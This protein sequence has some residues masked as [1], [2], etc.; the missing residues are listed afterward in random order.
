MFLNRHNLL[1]NHQTGTNFILA[2]LIYL[3][4]EELSESFKCN[5]H[6]YASN[7]FGVLFALIFNAERRECAAAK[8]VE[9]AARVIAELNLVRFVLLVDKANTS[10]VCELVR[11]SGYLERVEVRARDARNM[12]ELELRDLRKQQPSEQ[13]QT[14]NREFKAMSVGNEEIREPTREDHVTA[15]MTALRTIDMIDCL[16]VRVDEI[17]SQSS[18][19]R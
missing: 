14:N 1:N 3:V 15:T 11:S 13:V 4:K 2:Y 7:N 12:Y 5:D 16:R 9:E 18:Q 17:L 19:D 8:L 6:F 10:R